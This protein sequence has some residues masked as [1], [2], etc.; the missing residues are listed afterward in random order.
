MFRKRSPEVSV[1]VAA[2]VCLGAAACSGHGA[3]TAESRPGPSLSAAALAPSTTA[4]EVVQPASK[5]VRMTGKILVA[6]GKPDHH[7]IVERDLAT[8][9]DSCITSPASDALNPQVMPDG[10]VVY[11]ANPSG[12]Y[13]IYR[14]QPKNGST[15][16]LTND[17]ANDYDPAPTP[18]GD[19]LY[20]SNKDDG[21]GDIWRMTSDGG[22]QHNMTPGRSNTE[23]WGPAA[24]T[25]TS[26]IYTSS[27]ADDGTMSKEQLF[28]SGDLWLTD[29]SGEHQL[30]SKAWPDW[31]PKV[32]PKHP[33][34][35][36]YTSKLES[37]PT[38]PDTIFKLDYKTPGAQPQP[39]ISKAYDCSDEAPTPNGTLLLACS[40]NGGYD[41]MAHT[42]N[43]GL[44]TL[45]EHQPGGDVLSPVP[46]GAITA[47]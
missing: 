8:G 7:V 47:S 26:F 3:V 11:T 22:N 12:N 19:I 17:G 5:T 35:V 9:K 45:I 2:A 10:S 29:A 14:F 36:W 31:Y 6:A 28:A 33:S 21:Y 15:T 30:T 42:P 25:D 4:C 34:T 23:E 37:D 46:V 18:S 41:A 27:H 16:R 24:V 20:K 39:V 1:A 40:P 43:G 32:D 13:Q 38:G 44:V